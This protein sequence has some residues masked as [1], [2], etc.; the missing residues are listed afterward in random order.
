[1][2]ELNS[3]VIPGSCACRA[4]PHRRDIPRSLPKFQLRARLIQ[5]MYWW[6]GYVCVSMTCRRRSKE[7]P[8]KKKTR[9]TQYFDNQAAGQ[10]QASKR[11]SICSNEPA[12]SRPQKLML[13]I[14]VI[15]LKTELDLAHAT[16]LNPNCYPPLA[17]AT[18]SHPSQ[19]DG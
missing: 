14:A 10:R 15:E 2:P 9:T 17:P 1:V 8:K 12:G 11:S 16:C 4:Y 7:R 13:V 18:N 19:Q 3:L 6:G 5:G